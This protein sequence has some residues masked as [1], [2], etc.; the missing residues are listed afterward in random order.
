MRKNGGTV[1]EPSIYD[2][3]P[4][5]QSATQPPAATDSNP[6]VP[7]QT[8]AQPVQQ[9]TVTGMAAPSALLPAATNPMPTHFFGPIASGN[10]NKKEM[11]LTLLV[12][13]FDFD[14]SKGP[15]PAN[16]EVDLPLNSVLMDYRSVTTLAPDTT[17]NATLGTTPGGVDIMAIHAVSAGNPGWQNVNA[18]SPLPVKFYLNLTPAAGPPTV[19]KFS[20][21]L[22]YSR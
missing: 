9:N 12:K 20:I 15:V 2:N 1:A 18:V 19:G 5:A 16:T 22:S 13:R 17:L 4:A 10:P 8:P 11:G 21:F 7:A 3:T 14:V 6:P